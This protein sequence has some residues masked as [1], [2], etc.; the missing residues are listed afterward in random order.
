MIRKHRK[1]KWLFSAALISVA[2]LI[3]ARASS[4]SL[5]APDADRFALSTCAQKA[6]SS[7]ASGDDLATSYGSCMGGSDSCCYGFPETPCNSSGGHFQS[8]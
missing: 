7:G 3:P 8:I 4:P 5:P 6:V 2:A 1:K